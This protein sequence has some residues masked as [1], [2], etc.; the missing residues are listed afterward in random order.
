MV[1]ATSLLLFAAFPL[2]AFAGGGWED[3]PFPFL[4]LFYACLYVLVGLPIMGLGFVFGSFLRVRTTIMVL[5]CLTLILPIGAYALRDFSR[6]VDAAWVSAFLLLAFSPV[7]F[8]GWRIG[9][10]DARRHITVNAHL[11]GS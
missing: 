9:Q 3:A 5:F 4:A 7:I 8:W 6:A 11:R 2:P 1:R 10:K